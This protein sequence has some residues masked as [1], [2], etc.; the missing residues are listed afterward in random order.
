MSNVKLAEEMI[1]M[2]LDENFATFGKIKAAEQ[3]L[4]KL[5]DMCGM[6]H[7]NDMMDDEM[8]DDQMEDDMMDDA[9]DP[10]D[11][12]H[13]PNQD[14]MALYQSIRKQLGEWKQMNE[15][16]KSA[17][18]KYFDSMLKKYGVTSPAQLDNAKKKAFFDAV[19]KGWKGKKETD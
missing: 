13:V 2:I 17:Y 8:A 6:P 3:K 10:N 7:E 1:D 16:D 18:K 11:I 5:L 12:G 19:D 9:S 15:D 4:H 14:G